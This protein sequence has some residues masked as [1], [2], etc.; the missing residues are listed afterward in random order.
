[1][2]SYKQFVNTVEERIRERSAPK[3]LLSGA[4]ILERCKRVLDIFCGLLG[5]GLVSLT[6]N[7]RTFQNGTTRLS[8][9]SPT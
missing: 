2:K 1:M 7:I 5:N 4:A 8:N 3:R 6:N 9:A